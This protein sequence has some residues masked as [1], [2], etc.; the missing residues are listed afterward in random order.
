MKI[1]ITDDKQENLYLLESL[2]KGSGFEVVAALNGAEALEKLRAEDVD[3]II[4]DILMPVMDGFQLCR[5][6]K[7][8]EGLKNIPFI[9]YTATYTEKKDEEFALKL[10][11]DKYLRKPMEPEEFIKIIQGVVRDAEEGKAGRGEPVAEE[12]KEV[13]K[14]YS[15]RL[16]RKLE[17]KM[18]DLQEREHDLEERVK[19]LN[20]LYNI[21]KVV[22]EPGISLGGILQRTAEL[23]PPAWQYPEIAC[24]RIILE[25][26][27]FKT[28]NFKE[29]SWSQAGDIVVRGEPIGAVKVCYLEQRPESDEGPFLKEEAELIDAVAER[30]GRIIERKRVEKELAEE[31][32]NLERTVESRTEELRQ[33][34]KTLEDTNLRLEE[35][36]RHKNQFLSSMSHELRT[37]LNAVLGFADL[38]QGQFFGKLNEK[39]L[40]YVTQIDGSGK[41]LLALINDLLDMAKIDAGSMELEPEEIHPEECMNGVAAMMNAQFRKKQLTVETSIDPEVPSVTADGRKWKQIM[42]N[43]LSNAIKYTPEGGRIGIRTKMEGDFLRIEVSDTGVGIEP[44]EQEKIF[45]EFHQAEHVRDEQLGGTGIGLAL[46]RRLVEL[47]GGKIGVESEPGSGSTFWFTLPLGEGAA[48]EPSAAVGEAE[49]AEPAVTGRRILVAE[50][51]DANLSM[52]LDMLRVHDHKVAV[53]KNGQEAVDLAQSHK[54]ELILMDVRMPVIDGLEA[55]RQVRAMQEFAEIPIIALTASV[56]PEAEKRCLD[57][58]C[59]EHLAKPIQSKDLFAVLQRHLGEGS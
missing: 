5:A 39:Q 35:A 27:E 16:V 26:Q 1:L 12:E 52:I 3:M 59:T 18:L 50:D 37:P 51:N 7:G 32:R 34:L 20:C 9:F 29:T 44:E 31:H 10:G 25:G 21:A 8:D 47:H 46:T 38:M 58:G 55:T 33:S 40:S 17:D 4:S 57:A 22:E 28:K 45:S 49:A 24:G 48:E 54:P 6:C 42:L 11:V 2:L 15:E 41:H 30:L 19:E 43:L 56:G 13:F 23:I 14:L 36:N 53:A